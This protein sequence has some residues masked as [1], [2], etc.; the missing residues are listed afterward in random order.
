MHVR[1]LSNSHAFMRDH[2]QDESTQPRP[3]QL[4]WRPERLLNCGYSRGQQHHKERGSKT[5]TL[6]HLHTHLGD[7]LSDPL[8][9]KL[10]RCPVCLS[11]VVWLNFCC[12]AGIRFLSVFGIY[13][14]ICGFNFVNVKLILFNLFCWRKCNSI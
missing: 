7:K 4:S 13:N 10:Q 9:K 5:H 1:V 11:L 3:L 14:S 8:A 12:P 6:T 2:A